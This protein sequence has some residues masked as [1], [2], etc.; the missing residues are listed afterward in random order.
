MEADW[1]DAYRVNRY[2]QGFGEDASAT[3]ALG[4]F[5][6]FPVWMWRNTEVLNFISWL[7][8]YNASLPDDIRKTRFFGLDLY[9]LHASARA[10][11]EYL[12]KIDPEAARRARTR[13]ACFEHF[14]EDVQAYGQAASFGLTRSC[15][16]EVVNQLIEMRRRASEWANRDGRLEPDHFFAAEQNARLVANAE[17]YYRTMFSTLL[18]LELRDEH[19]VAT[20]DALV[21]H[22]GSSAKFAVWAHNSHL[23]NAAAT[24]MSRRGELNV[25]QLVRERFGKNAI[26]LGFTTYTGSVTAASDW[27]GRRSGSSYGPALPG[28]YE[29]LFH[30]VGKDF[31]LPLRNSSRLSGAMKER[32]ERAIGVIYLPETERIRHYFSAHLGEQFDAVIHLDETRA[33]E[34]LERISQWEMGEFPETYP[35]AV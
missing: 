11:L 32:L 23:G 15:E 25:G 29:A 24:E 12:N 34:P 18:V 27:E 20:L 30:D 10:V 9:S 4:G 28:S 7:H 5:R 3:E 35:F 26:L 13:Y 22:F 17:R 8:S 2:V 31:L 16:D 21:H 33:L 1:P 14:G 6:R 19:M